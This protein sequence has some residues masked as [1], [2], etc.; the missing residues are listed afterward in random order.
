MSH[1]G[2]VVQAKQNNMSSIQ[3]KNYQSLLQ[4]TWRAR[5]K[6]KLK[7]KNKKEHTLLI[8]FYFFLKG[9]DNIRTQYS[10]NWN[11]YLNPPGYYTRF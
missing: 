7:Y 8:L 3:D 11:N 6:L 10:C 5:M 1:C 4:P 2:L 9:K